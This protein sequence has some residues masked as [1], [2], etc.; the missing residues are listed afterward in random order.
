MDLVDVFNQKIIEFIQDVGVICPDVTELQSLVSM[1]LLVDRMIAIRMF[2]SYAGRYEAAILARDE[3]FFLNESFDDVVS[4]AAGSPDIIARIKTVWRTLTDE[5][6]DIIW[7]YVQLLLVLH[8][9]LVRS[10]T[11]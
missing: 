6:K 5:N 8:K 11:T 7:K 2:E 4:A 10:K 3:A 1:G 9:K